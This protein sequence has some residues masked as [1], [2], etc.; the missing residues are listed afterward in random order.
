M[1]RIWWLILGGAIVLAGL[2]VVLG[3]IVFES[4][5]GGSAD[6]TF[7]VCTPEKPVQSAGNANIAAQLLGKGYSRN[8]VIHVTDKKT[9]VPVHGATVKVQGTMDCPHF[10]PLYQKKLREASNGTYKGGYQLV[11]QGHWTMHIL[12]RSKQGGAT[13]SALPVTVK[14]PG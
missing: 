9:G 3:F 7:P 6:A 8:I 12:V 5:G 10:M 4:G 14:I 1:R 11:M 2:L 13:T